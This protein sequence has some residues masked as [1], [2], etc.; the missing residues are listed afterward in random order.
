[1]AINTFSYLW[2]KPFDD[3]LRLLADEGYQRFEIPLSAPH[4]W[5]A[6]LGQSERKAVA[7]LLSEKKLEIVSLNAGGFDINIA[8]PASEIRDFA[9]GYI[10][11]VMELAEEWAVSNVVI[12]PGTAR[13][14]ISPPYANVEGWMQSSLL[15]MLPTAAKRGTHLL[16]ENTPYCFRPKIDDLIEVV[17]WANDTNLGIV[18]D[19][20]NAAFIG[21]DPAF[22]LRRAVPHVKL[23]HISDSGRDQWGHDQIGT[24]D[25]PFEELGR[26]IQDTEFKGP[27]VLEVIREQDTERTFAESISKLRELSWAV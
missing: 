8:S 10:E 6:S 1:M 9:I 5:P 19:V 12:S 7:Q 17:E 25:V 4:C 16:L 21:E 3:C 18:Y 22:G 2:R 26:A 11:A 23:I 27:I 24:G 14:M 15:R 20:A 13:P